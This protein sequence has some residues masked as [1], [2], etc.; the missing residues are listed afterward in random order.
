[1]RILAIGDIVA[2]DGREFVYNNLNRIRDFYRIDFCIANG[3]NSANTN[4]ITAEIADALITR[5]V[6]VI[7]MGN[8]T[9][10]NREAEH[11]LEDNPNIIRPLNFPPET[12]GVGYVVKD[13]GI[14]RIGVINLIGRVDMSPADCPFHAVERALKGM[15]ADIILV[16]MHAEAT[17]E[18]L[19]MG[20]F[21]D[22]KVSG[23]FGTHTHVQTADE[24]IL[25][26]G[27]G[28]IS[29]LGMTGVED[30]VLGVK[31]E[32]IIDFYYHAGKRYRF[33]KAEGEVWFNGC[34]F[35]IDPKTGKTTAIE[36]V[37]FSSSNLPY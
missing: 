27:T 5:G 7:T 28:Y 33:E 11:V 13:T 4:G 16:D 12:E 10:A 30:S 1:M 2:E 23:V 19:A 3:E 35:D 36:R 20:Y 25:K 6:D 24:R 18:R 32:I 26:G 15:D 9:F 31:K 29:D 34:I 17:S 37:R 8:H 14:A 21:L 22:G